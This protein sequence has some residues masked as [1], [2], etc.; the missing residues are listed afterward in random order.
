VIHQKVQTIIQLSSVPQFGPV[1]LGR[2]FDDLDSLETPFQFLSE[3]E[4]ADLVGQAGLTEA[5]ADAFLSS[6]DEAQR[7]VG[8]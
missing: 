3:F 5:Q 8:H 4:R 2:L 7:M 1:R 6:R